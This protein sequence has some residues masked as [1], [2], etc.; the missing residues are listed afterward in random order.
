MYG[1]SN[2]YKCIIHTDGKRESTIHEILHVKR[3]RPPYDNVIEIPLSS[4]TSSRTT[5]YVSEP[6]LSGKHIVEGNGPHGR[7]RRCRRR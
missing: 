4:S 3:D 6:H 1:T 2:Y 5:H 7:E